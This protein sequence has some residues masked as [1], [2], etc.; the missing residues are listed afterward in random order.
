MCVTFLVSGL[1]HD[2]VWYVSFDIKQTQY[3]EVTCF[4]LTTGIIMLLERPFGALPPCQWMSRNLPSV[5]IATLLV[6]LHAPF[7]HWYYG[8]L[9]TCGCFSDVSIGLPLIKKM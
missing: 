4:F 6:M 7:A 2:Y 5:V 1:Y 3:F 9:I 8:D